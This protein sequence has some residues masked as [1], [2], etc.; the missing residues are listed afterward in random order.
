MQP[1]VA[2]AQVVDVYKR[3]V[4]LLPVVEDQPASGEIRR[5]EGG[6]D[7]VGWIAHQGDGGLTDLLKVEGADGADVYKRQ[8]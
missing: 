5:R 6:V 3:Q 2:V 4:Q 1:W 7:V 8:P